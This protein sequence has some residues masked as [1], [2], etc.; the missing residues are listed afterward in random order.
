MSGDLRQTD[1]A[2]A[3]GRQAAALRKAAWLGSF[4]RALWELNGRPDPVIL[5]AETARLA[6]SPE[7]ADAGLFRAGCGAVAFVDEDGDAHE[8]HSQGRPPDIDTA[9]D[10]LARKHLGLCLDP[11][12]TGRAASS[13][14][15]RYGWG[16]RETN[17]PSGWC[18][19]HRPDP[20]TQ[21]KIH[22]IARRAERELVRA[23]YGDLAPVR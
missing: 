4:R 2:K 8:L 12:C 20:K 18:D 17:R 6:G 19:D 23:R 22:T 16:E 13:V 1:D 10:L 14:R 11:R 3:A 21:G 7:V 15:Y 5:S 9:T